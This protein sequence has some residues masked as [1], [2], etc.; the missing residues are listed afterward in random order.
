[1]NMQWLL[2]GAQNRGWYEKLHKCFPKTPETKKIQG[3]NK[4]KCMTTLCTGKS[5]AF[6]S[7][8]S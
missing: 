8:L 6:A 1:M 7:E 3:K 4:Y 2:L 5:K